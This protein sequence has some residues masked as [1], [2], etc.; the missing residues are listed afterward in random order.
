MQEI[1]IVGPPEGVAR[2]KELLL[3]QAKK[4][5]NEANVELACEQRW[6][7]MLIGQKGE[8]IQKIR[9][10]YPEVQVSFPNSTAKKP[11]CDKVNIRGPKKDVEQV[12]SSSFF[13][14]FV[15]FCSSA[16]LFHP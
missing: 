13:K 2:A 10:K 9:V 1:E 8:S 3:E 12:N 6:H 11:D 7:R 14:L 4:I 5:E 16:K 15:S